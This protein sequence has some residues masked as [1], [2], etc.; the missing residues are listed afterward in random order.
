MVG[1]WCSW[2]QWEDIAGLGMPPIGMWIVF[3]TSLSWFPRI[4]S[5]GQCRLSSSSVPPEQWVALPTRAHRQQ[6]YPKPLPKTCHIWAFDQALSH[7]LIL[8]AI[9]RVIRFD[10]PDW[11]QPYIEFNTSKRAAAIDDFEKSFYRLMTLSLF[12]KT[13]ERVD[14]RQIIQL[15]MM[16]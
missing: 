10:Q 6:N 2:C 8:T 9:H 11:I 3:A 12:G 5:G 7:G 15:A 13:M 4:Y 14:L 16:D 1:R